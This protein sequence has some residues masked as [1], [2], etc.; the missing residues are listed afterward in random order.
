M[1]PLKLH[2]LALLKPIV[3]SAGLIIALTAGL[4]I[5]LNQYPALV[6]LDPKYR[7]STSALGLICAFAT[8][9]VS[10]RAGLIGVMFA[11]PLQPKLA[12]QIQQYFGYGRILP[13]HNAGLDLVA[14][15]ALGTLINGIWRRRFWRDTIAM[16]WPV[17]LAM[18]LVTFS[19]IVAIARNLKQTSSFFRFDILVYN[20]FHLR[21]LDWHDDFR[22]LFDWAVYGCAFLFIALLVPLLKALKKREYYLFIPLI[23]ALV[24]AAIV[25]IRQSLYGIG[26]TAV[27]MLFRSESFGF[28]ALGFQD[29]IHSFAGQ[30][31]I[32]AIGLWGLI[33]WSK[34]LPLRVAL[35]LGVIPLSW[36]ALFLSKSKATFALALLTQLL[37][38][39]CWLNRH[40]QYF[41]PIVLGC[42]ATLFIFL[43]G[44]LFFSESWLAFI[45]SSL[46]LAGVRDLAAFNL[47]LSY[48][49]EVYAA[50]LKMFSL[51]PIFGM[52]Q[53][54]YYRQSANHDL[55]HSFFLSIQQNGENGHNYFLHT[56][57]ETGLVGGIVFGILLIYPIVLTQNR[58]ALIP[59]AIGLGAIL[60][61]NIFAH[62]L[63]VRETLLIAAS[64]LALMYVYAEAENDS[65]TLSTNESINEKPSRALKGLASASLCAGLGVL[66]VVIGLMTYSAQAQFPFTVDTQC[67]KNR[68][69]DP[70]GWT[71]GL[72]ELPLTDD[73]TSVT[74]HLK[75]NQLILD[76]RPLAMQFSLRDLN[77]TLL[78]SQSF[79]LTQAG[80][81]SFTMEVPAD[82]LLK[83]SQKILSVTLERCFIPRNLGI[84]EDSRRL[85]VQIEGIDINTD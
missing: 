46:Q 10:P 1:N 48:R 33:Y 70:D 40:R 41:W 42:V 19:A 28:M 11:L 16:P 76:Q 35:V 17:G 69:V 80:P 36:V 22:P 20:L 51:F 44:G 71:A 37:V 72:F 3:S 23:V 83:R 60:I 21:S 39:L 68:P 73:V 27:Q 57:V 82:S 74:I 54:E 6:S 78:S 8:S 49:P 14:G 56:L 15:L 52:G 4:L 34:N 53:G 2:P 58:R 26:F 30:M 59:A 9:L 7:I 13:V 38:L 75:P 81:R 66:A 31:L 79:S 24:M 55:T 84:N 65:F 77:S 85:G 5:I 50:G 47:A 32:G 63:L 67:Y 43:L 64:M 29:D 45:K 61:G 62:S 25:G 18:L 12:W